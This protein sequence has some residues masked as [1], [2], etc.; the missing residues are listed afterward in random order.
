MFHEI[1][2]EFVVFLFRLFAAAA[3]AL[4]PSRFFCSRNFK[5][6]IPVGGYYMIQ[7]VSKLSLIWIGSIIGIFF[8]FPYQI[9]IDLSFVSHSFIYIIY[10]VFL[11]FNQTFIACH[12]TWTDRTQKK[13]HLW[14]LKLMN[15]EKLSQ[16]TKH[17]V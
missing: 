7:S 14:L 13:T 5:R 10:T 12:S 16:L 4:F 9:S 6:N 17:E 11:S 3:A 15:N 8:L 2:T 1:D